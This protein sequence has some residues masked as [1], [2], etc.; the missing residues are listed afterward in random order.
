MYLSV[1]EQ[2]EA[3]QL[4]TLLVHSL[5]GDGRLTRM[6]QGELLRRGRD[7]GDQLQLGLELSDAP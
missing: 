5:D 2:G 1:R 3:G 6:V 7:A 4:R